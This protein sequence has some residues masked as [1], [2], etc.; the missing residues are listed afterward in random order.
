[1]QKE[2]VRCVLLI[3]TELV[4]HPSIIDTDLCLVLTWC[5]SHRT[6][7]R[8]RDRLKTLHSLPWKTADDELFNA[9]D[10]LA[11]TPVGETAELLDDGGILML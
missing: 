5:I 7:Q 8:I 11:D 10:R 6:L 2:Y 4:C 1:M 3:G 9:V